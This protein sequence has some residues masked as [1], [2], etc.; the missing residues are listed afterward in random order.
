MNDEPK[1]RDKRPR[2]KYTVAIHKDKRTTVAGSCMAVSASHA[3]HIIRARLRELGLPG[4]VGE[5]VRAK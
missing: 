4:E 5:A 1:K 3:Q 2:L